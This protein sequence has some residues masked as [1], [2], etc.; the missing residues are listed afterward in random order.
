MGSIQFRLKA[1]ATTFGRDETRP[2]IKLPPL[3]ERELDRC[4]LSCDLHPLLPLGVNS[5]TAGPVCLQI[6]KG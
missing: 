2:A 3:L 4:R 6:I 1:L 5:I